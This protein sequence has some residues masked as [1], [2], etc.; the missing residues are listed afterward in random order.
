MTVDTLSLIILPRCRQ[1]VV[2]HTERDQR[3]RHSQETVVINGD[4]ITIIKGLSANEMKDTKYPGRTGSF[5]SNRRV[6]NAL[7]Q[8]RQNSVFLCFHRLRRVLLLV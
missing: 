8:I 3:L 6:A 7:F 5:V 4:H 1:S 2:F